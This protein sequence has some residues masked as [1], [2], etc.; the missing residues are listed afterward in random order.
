MATLVPGSHPLL[1]YDVQERRDYLC[2][3][4]SMA[5]ADG[6]VDDVERERLE[7]LCST[8]ELSK[9][10]GDGACDSVIEAARNTPD[11]G[12]IFSRLT[13]SE[14]RYA[15][16][17]DL[18]DLAVGGDGDIAST[19]DAEL[20]Q[21]ADALE[22]NPSQLAMTK[23]FVLDRRGQK[24]T[25]PT[26][27]TL[28]G[29]AGVGVPVAALAVMAPLGAPIVAGLGLAAA[30]GIGSFVSVKWLAKRFRRSDSASTQKDARDSSDAT[31]E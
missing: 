17:V 18:I 12:D 30:L 27:E 21:F 19:E 13:G 9:E 22:I 10:L 20:Q 15:L 31:G 6:T 11:L 7:T 8:F 1:A 28:A 14:L 3:V 24:D 4:A 16:M 29:L 5:L 23:R 2:V 26:P 25:E